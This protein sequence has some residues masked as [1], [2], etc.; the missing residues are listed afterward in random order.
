MHP[1]KYTW[2]L[3]LL[4][5]LVVFSLGSAELIITAIYQLNLASQ[6]ALQ[7]VSAL[8]TGLIVGWVAIGTSPLI[9]QML[10]TFRLF[11]RLESLTHPLLLRLS[12]EAP[13]TYHHSLQVGTL[14]NAAARAIG[15]DP[16]LARL[17]GYY[18]DIGKLTQPAY[19]IENQR[20][21]DNPLDAL[22]PREAARAIIAHI[23]DGLALGAQHHLPAE[24]LALIAQHTG[25][26]TVR[27]F[28]E[29]ARGAGKRTVN[30]ETFRYPGPK[31]Q[32]REAGIV[33]LADVIEAKVR[34][35]TNS[36]DRTLRQLVDETISEKF[37]D[38]QL[39]LAG[40][41]SNDLPL[42]RIA[43]VAALGTMLHQRIAY[44]VATNPPVRERE[45]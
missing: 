1:F 45:R 36:D 33:M 21:N 6:L 40:F 39:E 20:G 19:F 14:A 22:T 5:S 27:Y 13:G 7:A 4:I 43:F 28:L 17:G 3:V 9:R 11:T 25:T 29:K 35:L 31:P 18:H 41:Y 16:L 38:G 26:T 15:A 34:L 10:A 12:H 23:D 24:L 30:P 32:T 42:L 44:P 2:V 8:I 37:E